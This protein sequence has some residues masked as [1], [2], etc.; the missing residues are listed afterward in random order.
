VRLGVQLDDE[1]GLAHRRRPDD[2][3]ERLVGSRGQASSIN[4]GRES[5]VT[6]SPLELGRRIK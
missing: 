3:A 1:I 4:A 2:D 6:P 5:R